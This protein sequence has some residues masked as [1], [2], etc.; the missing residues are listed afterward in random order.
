MHCE[1]G[2][3]RLLATDDTAALTAV[4]QHMI[5]IDVA[6]A[7]AFWEKYSEILLDL[8]ET[9]RRAP[10]NQSYG[11]REVH[12]IDPDGTLLFFGQALVSD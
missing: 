7:D 3:I 8:P 4:K 2:A 11:Q 9:H 12:V 10:F 5:Y 6:S 1:G